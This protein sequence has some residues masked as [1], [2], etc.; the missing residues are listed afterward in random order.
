MCGKSTMLVQ[1]RRQ[2]AID[3]EMCMFALT[4]SIVEPKNIKEA[5][6]DSE[7]IDKQCMRTFHQFDRLKDE[8]HTEFRNKHDLVLKVMLRR[9]WTENGISNGPQRKEV[10]GLRSQKGVVDL[11][12]SQKKSTF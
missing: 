10:Y 9:G 11:R 12:S 3:L 1:T 8:D 6:A 7:W 2:L 4:V 5:M